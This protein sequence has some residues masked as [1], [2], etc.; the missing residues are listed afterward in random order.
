MGAGGKCDPSRLHISDLRAATS[1]P[2]ATKLR[3]TLKR[4]F[5][6][7]ADQFLDDMDRLSVVYSSEKTVVK[8]AELTEEQKRQGV[9]NFGAVDNMRIRILPVLG[10]MP[11]IMGQTLAAFVLCELGGKP[12]SV[13]KGLI[14]SS[15]AVDYALN[16]LN[17]LFI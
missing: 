13:S 15:S 8:L 16:K 9:R 6:D 2:L 4:I 14:H 5:K 7:A 17:S 3:V 10:T 1:D 11:A 12:F